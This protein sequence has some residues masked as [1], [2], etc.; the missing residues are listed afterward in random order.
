MKRLQ[1]VG[2]RAFFIRISKGCCE[3]S[4][5]DSK[6]FKNDDYH[7]NNGVNQANLVSDNGMLMTQTLGWSI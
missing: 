5:N 6:L 2:R 1:L 3:F 4:K 7:S